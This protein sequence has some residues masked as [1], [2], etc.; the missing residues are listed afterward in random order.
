ML[1]SEASLQTFA[2]NCRFPEA[3]AEVV[4]GAVTSAM[5]AVTDDWDDH[6][7]VLLIIGKDALEPVAQVVEVRLLRDLRLKKLRLDRLRRLEALVRIVVALTLALLVVVEGG[8]GG[9][10]RN[11]V[12]ATLVASLH[13][14][15]R[16]HALRHVGQLDSTRE[17]LP[18]N[19]H[20]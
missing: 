16:R 12:E 11:D 7:H 15:G 19:E 8:S 10:G 3:L 5:A 13:H 2:L 18:S 14:R 1:R 20:S 9:L 6:L 17:E 4:L